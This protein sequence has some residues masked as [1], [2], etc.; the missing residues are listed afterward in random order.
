MSF[1]REHH[2][3]GKQLMGN[4]FVLSSNPYNHNGKAIWNSIREWRQI[5]KKEHS[6]KK[7][8]D[9]VKKT[10]LKC[11]QARNNLQVGC[12]QN[13]KSPPN[14]GKSI[15]EIHTLRLQYLHCSSYTHWS[16]SKTQLALFKQ[17]VVH[18]ARSTLE[19]LALIYSDSPG[20]FNG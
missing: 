20:N 16:E 18:A 12:D 6:H 4:S 11:P 19:W 8:I 9:F 15:H 1:C 13:I 3:N 10:G 14:L 2:L 7:S 5:V 17:T